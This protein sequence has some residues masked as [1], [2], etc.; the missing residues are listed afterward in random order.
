[1]TAS[2]E[3][4]ESGAAVHDQDMD[5][6]NLQSESCDDRYMPTCSTGRK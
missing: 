5:Y 2:P 3:I 1:M 6:E 4:D